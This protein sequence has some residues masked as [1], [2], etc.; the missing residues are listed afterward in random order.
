MLKLHKL[1]IYYR[2]FWEYKAPQTGFYLFPLVESISP[3]C[4]FEARS[5]NSAIKST[6]LGIVPRAE[7]ELSK[8]TFEMDTLFACQLH[9]YSP[10]LALTPSQGVSRYDVR[11]VT[12]CIE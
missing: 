10:V 3:V 2:G 1:R 8:D 9:A 5:W 11:G 4:A 6:K 7:P 12:G